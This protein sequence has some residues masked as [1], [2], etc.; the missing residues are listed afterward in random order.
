MSIYPIADSGQQVMD[1]W[2]YFILINI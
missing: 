2:I 1:I